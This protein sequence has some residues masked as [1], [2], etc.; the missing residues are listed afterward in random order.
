MWR[1]VSRQRLREQTEDLRQF[2]IVAGVT[3]SARGGGALI[4]TLYHISRP[5][6]GA[7][8]IHWILLT[9]D[10]G[11]NDLKRC[12]ILNIVTA[13]AILPA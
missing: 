12:K 7:C 6:P 8:V 5:G 3:M 1:G 2:T 4:I 10:N 11:H 13:S 9:S